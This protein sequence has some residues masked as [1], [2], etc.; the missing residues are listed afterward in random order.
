M[1]TWQQCRAEVFCRSE[2]RIEKRR[3]IRNRVL[4]LCIPL[5]LVVVL[6]PVL[7]PAQKSAGGEPEVCGSGGILQA[8]IYDPHGSAREITDPVRAERLLSMLSG[9]YGRPEKAPE[10]IPEYGI[11]GQTQEE[12][13]YTITFSGEENL[14]YTLSGDTL[15]NETTGAQ[16]VLDSGE[17]ERLK[18][19]ITD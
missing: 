11:M 4:M 7:R 14:R 5:C 10:E 3:K 19:A 17:L 15:T 18:A 12:T 13:V 1:R 16:V 6:L 2:K 9:F 8:E